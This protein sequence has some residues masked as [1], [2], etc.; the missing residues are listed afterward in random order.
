M[1]EPRYVKIER[2]TGTWYGIVLG[3][4]PCSAKCTYPLR[5]H[6]GCTTCEHQF[7][8]IGG[9]VVEDGKVK[10]RGSTLAAQRVTDI[11]Q[12]EFLHRYALTKL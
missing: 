2:A 10:P 5:G 7:L 6:V 12:E 1:S 9:Y 4:K 8:C 11:T 3:T